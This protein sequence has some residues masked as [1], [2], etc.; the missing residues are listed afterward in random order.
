MEIYEVENVEYESVGLLVE[1]C[2]AVF[3]IWLLWRWFN[4]KGRNGKARVGNAGGQPDNPN[5]GA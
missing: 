5:N 1:V 2:G 3:V 4:G